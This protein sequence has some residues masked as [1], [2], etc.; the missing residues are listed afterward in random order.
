MVGHNN[1]Q[2]MWGL[3]VDPAKRTV[4]N[5]CSL[6]PLPLCGVCRKQED[7]VHS[8]RRRLEEA[9]MADMLVH[10]EDSTNEADALKKEQTEQEGV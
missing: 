3:V 7:L 5:H 1:T 10:I 9:L 6:T 2:L 8:V 4:I